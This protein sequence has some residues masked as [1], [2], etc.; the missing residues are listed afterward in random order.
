MAVSSTDL[1]ARRGTVL[2]RR[3]D[4]AA[5]AYAVDRGAVRL[6]TTTRDGRTVVFRLT[7]PGEAFGFLSMLD[8]DARPCDAIVLTPCRLVVVPHRFIADEVERSPPA[9]MALAREATRET[10][11]LRQ[12]LADLTVRDA[13]ERV[14]SA[15]FELGASFAVRAPDGVLI[16]IPLRHE[17]LAGLVGVARETVSRTLASLSARGF[18]RREGERYVVLDRTLAAAASSA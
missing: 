7:G 4:P 3:G 16:D 17:D 15:L 9:A 13:S 1:F 11:R 12:R 14:A 8:G 10:R 2:F 18:L 5:A 6:S